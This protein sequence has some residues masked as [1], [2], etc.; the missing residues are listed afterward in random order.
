MSLVDT[1]GISASF[2]ITTAIFL[3]VILSCISWG[4]VKLFQQRKRTA[5]TSLGVGGLLTVVYIVLVVTW[6]ADTF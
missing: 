1:S 2:F 3:F 4:V 5:W 6:L